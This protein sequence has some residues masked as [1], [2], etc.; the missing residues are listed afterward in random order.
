LVTGL[1]NLQESVMSEVFLRNDDQ[2]FVS[3]GSL[4]QEPEDTESQLD[5]D[6]FDRVKALEARSCRQ[7]LTPEFGCTMA[8]GFNTQAGGAR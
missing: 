7:R 2:T 5:N 8:Q 3:F 1:G 4:N 6:V